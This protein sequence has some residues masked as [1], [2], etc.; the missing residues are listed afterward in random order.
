MKT[1]S[2]VGE[3][4]GNTSKQMTLNYKIKNIQNVG[5]K[6]VENFPGISGMSS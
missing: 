2:L 3:D 5:L 6:K 4:S 1:Y